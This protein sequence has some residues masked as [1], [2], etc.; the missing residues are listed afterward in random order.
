MDAGTSPAWKVRLKIMSFD[1]QKLL[2]VLSGIWLLISFLLTSIYKDKAYT[3]GL[4]ISI[5]W[6]G[7]FMSPIWII[8]AWKYLISSKMPSK[9]FYTIIAFY[10]I[11]IMYEL[12]KP[13]HNNPEFALLTM[14]SFIVI[15]YMVDTY[16]QK[17]KNI[18][19]VLSAIRWVKLNRKKCL[20][21]GLPMIVVFS[22]YVHVENLEKEK[23]MQA[24]WDKTVA[25]MYGKNVTRPDV[26]KN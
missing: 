20:Q 1:K 9:I 24:F 15:Q 25:D 13:Y 14:I 16:P 7:I 23:Q 6:L 2:N 8:H 18:D 26:N 5:F 17:T 21:V 22:L 10:I 4:F 11:W 19:C 12:V 3:E